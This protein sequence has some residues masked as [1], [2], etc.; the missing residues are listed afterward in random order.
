MVE[1]EIKL[2]IDSV[3]SV[4]NKL[5]DL[6]FI[7]GDV[8]IESDTYFDN[9]NSDI[10]LSDKA[11]RIRETVNQTTY[12]RYYQ[13]NFK[14]K[15]YD[16]V[17]MTRPEYETRF[18]DANSMVMILKGL[19]YSPVDPKVIKL[20]RLLKTS[21]INACIDTVEGLGDYLEL[22]SVVLSEDIKDEKLSKINSILSELGYSINDTT[23]T[24]Y[25]SALQNIS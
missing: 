21:E 18:D 2:K 9:K 14:D 7:E 13:L 20:R 23:T 6:G 1:V 5:K 12:E 11:V 24:S 4:I 8:F 22:E 16:N 19:G 25:L 17:S 3:D 10:R 15:K